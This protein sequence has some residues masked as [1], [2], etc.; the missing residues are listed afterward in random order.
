MNNVLFAEFFN[1]WDER[2]ALDYSNDLKRIVGSFNGAYW[3]HIVLMD[4]WE[5]GTPEIEPII[6]RLE[7]WCLRNKVQNTA[8]VF[9]ADALK[10]YQLKKM[11]RGSDT[12]MYS[13]FADIHSACEWI[14]SKGFSPE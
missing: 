7:L 12:N 3:A 8:V 11:V 9:S 5:L 13:E 6:K 10:H 2:V 4:K 1:S 14:K